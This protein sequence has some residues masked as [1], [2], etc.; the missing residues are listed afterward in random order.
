MIGRVYLLVTLLVVSVTAFSPSSTTTP[1]KSFNKF[2]FQHSRIVPS[3]RLSKP[4]RNLSS[5]NEPE[6]ETSSINT[7]TEGEKK[8]ISQDGTFYDDEVRYYY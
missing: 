5:S 7:V 4:I 8:V 2:T 3:T 6:S 1:F